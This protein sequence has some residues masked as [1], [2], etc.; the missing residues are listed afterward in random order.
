MA[1]VDEPVECHVVGEAPGPRFVGVCGPALVA[2]VLGHRISS[3]HSEARQG[4]YLR[5]GGA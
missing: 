2:L 1:R 4:V 3:S 5:S